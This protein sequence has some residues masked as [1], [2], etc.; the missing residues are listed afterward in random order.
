MDFFL[1]KLC[2]SI[3]FFDPVDRVLDLFFAEVLVGGQGDDVF[4]LGFR[5][6]EIPRFVAQVLAAVLHMER[7]GIM[8][9]GLD[10]GGVQELQQA[11]T[12]FRLDDVE[13]IDVL[14]ALAAL[15]PGALCEFR[16]LLLSLRSLGTNPQFPASLHFL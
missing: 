7:H 6:R 9:L 14:R 13:V 8:D 1:L 2:S 12:V 3:E 10:A 15:L 11:V 4:G 16:L 5:H